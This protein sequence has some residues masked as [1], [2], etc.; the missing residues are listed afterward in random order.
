ML[1][2]HLSATPTPRKRARL[3]IGAV[4]FNQRQ[5]ERAEEH[6]KI[7]LQISIEFGDGYSQAG[8]PMLNIFAATAEILVKTSTPE[9]AKSKQLTKLIKNAR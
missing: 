3:G 9:A 8:A 4:G 6:Y 2:D 7:A 1:L 5:W